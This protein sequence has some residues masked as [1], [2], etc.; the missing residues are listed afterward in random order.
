M[1]DAFAG[2]DL[3]A[4]FQDVAAGGFDAQMYLRINLY[5]HKRFPHDLT[6]VRNL[7]TAYTRQETRIPG[8]VG[9]AAAR[10]LVLRR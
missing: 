2:S 4:Y 1:T 5:A 6:F 8:G 3:E 10:A 7:L 9:E